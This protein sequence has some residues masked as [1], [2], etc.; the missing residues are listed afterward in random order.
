MACPYCGEPVEITLDPGS[1]NEQEY[2]EDCEVC[3]QPWSV[4]V[5]YHADGSAEVTVTPLDA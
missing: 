3:C 4:R 5:H 2:V 1:G